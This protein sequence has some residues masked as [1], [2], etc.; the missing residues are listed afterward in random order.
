MIVPMK[1]VS[2]IV[3][4]DKKTEVLK[5]L[6][7][8]GTVHIE[9]TEGSGQSLTEL[10]EQISLLENALFT[11]GK[12]KNSEQKSADTEKAISIADEIAALDEEKKVE[13]VKSLEFFDKDNKKVE[14]LDIFQSP[15][16][17]YMCSDISEYVT[18]IKFDNGDFIKKTYNYVAVEEKNGEYSFSVLDKYFD[19]SIDAKDV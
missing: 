18:H 19:F 3:M 11:V 6:R 12:N 5:K 1:K 8:L 7:K 14:F 17:A 2:L 16:S 4:G 10:R 9:I 13:N 15:S